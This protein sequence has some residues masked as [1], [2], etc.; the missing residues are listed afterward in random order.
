MA[1]ENKDQRGG[2]GQ[3]SFL[4][5]VFMSPGPAQAPPE[6]GEQQHYNKTQSVYHSVK[7]GTVPPTADFLP[8]PLLKMRGVI[9]CSNLL[10]KIKMKSYPKNPAK[11]LLTQ[12]SKEI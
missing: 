2:G 11:T 7:M 12:S 9:L 4:S 1:K 10:M 8:S 3:D 6:L 5:E